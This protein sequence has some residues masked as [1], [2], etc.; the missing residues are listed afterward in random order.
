[1]QI[2]RKNH[3]LEFSCRLYEYGS[4]DEDSDMTIVVLVSPLRNTKIFVQD[5][6]EE[7]TSLTVAQMQILKKDRNSVFQC[8]IRGEQ[9][10]PGA[11]NAIVAMVKKS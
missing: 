5:G 8:L 9:I 6:N 10:T 7:M 11:F 2:G 1:M 4:P 3:V